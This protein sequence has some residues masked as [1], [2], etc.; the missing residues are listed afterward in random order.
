[1]RS[2]ILANLG[3]VIAGMVSFVLMGAG[4]SIFGPALPAFARQFGIETGEAGLLVSALWIGSAL[5]VAAMYWRGNDIVPRHGLAVLILGA[6]GIAAGIGWWATLAFTVLFGTGYGIS[7]V[8]YNR[9][10]LAI[11]GP[12]GPAMLA[13]LNAIFAAGAIVAPLA[14]VAAG[15]ST[16]LAYA[17]V[18]ALAAVAFLFAGGIGRTEAVAGGARYRF[19]PPILFFGAVGIGFEACLIGLGPLALIA[20]GAT[21]E[22]AAEL[23][24]LFF[25]SFLVSRTVL[26]GA[27]HL[28]PPFTLY[29][30]ALGGAGLV[31][32]ALALTGWTWL[33]APLGI[34]AGLFFPG[35]YV[36]GSALMGDDKRVGP[37]L[38]AAGLTGGISAPILL[39]RLMQAQGD[40]VLF[41][42]LAAV[43][44]AVAVAAAL[45]LRGV[46]REAAAAA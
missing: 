23:L 32:L 35:F 42:V 7:T 31:A 9:R 5:G 1:M 43:G 21:E 8:I 4:Q 36:A 15:S 3:L 22:G 10:M 17:A 38:I 46:N 39:S 37:T 26:V 41:P 18:A 13:F 16:R 45:M 11:F 33:F 20:L 28:I 6:A 27:A 30:C 29:T 2:L 40:A 25:V 19:H 14:F 34:F 44:L 24:S 12:R